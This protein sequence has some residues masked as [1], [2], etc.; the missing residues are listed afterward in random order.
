MTDFDTKIDTHFISAVLDLFE[1]AP[2]HTST[3]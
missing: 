2:T 3:N 1:N